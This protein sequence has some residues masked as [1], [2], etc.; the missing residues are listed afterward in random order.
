MAAD[1]STVTNVDNVEEVAAQLAG[2][3]LR[4]EV[5]TRG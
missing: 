2:A 3:Q 5:S 4:F 1:P